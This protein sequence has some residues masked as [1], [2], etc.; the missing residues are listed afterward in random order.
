MAVA[1]FAA[2]TAVTDAAVADA[3]A[4]V[5]AV[6]APA[7]TTSAAPSPL[8]VVSVAVPLCSDPRLLAVAT[9]VRRPPLEDDA[10][11]ASDGPDVE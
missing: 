5:A 4:V 9:G 7:E 3:A 2:D 10:A 11:T 6:A 1:A 8:I